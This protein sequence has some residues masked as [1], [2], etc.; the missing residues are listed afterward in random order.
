MRGRRERGEI[1]QNPKIM[2]DV[3]WNVIHILANGYSF[4][5]GVFSGIDD[6]VCSGLALDDFAKLVIPSKPD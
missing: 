3:P 1:E 4:N 6:Y 5:R 2:G